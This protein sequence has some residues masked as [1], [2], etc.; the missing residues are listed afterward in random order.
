LIARAWL[1][2]APS[3]ETVMPGASHLLSEEQRAAAAARTRTP[4]PSRADEVQRVASGA[5]AAVGPSAALAVQGAVGNAALGQVL[6]QRAGGSSRRGGGGREKFDELVRQSRGPGSRRSSQDSRRSSEDS[7]QGDLYNEAEMAL[8]V[9]DPRYVQTHDNQSAQAG[10]GADGRPEISFD[11]QHQPLHSYTDRDAW[12]MG[13]A[14][15]EPGHFRMQQTYGQTNQQYGLGDDPDMRWAN[16]PFAGPDGSQEFYASSARQMGHVDEAMAR[17]R[18]AVTA[19]RH[20][21]GDDLTEHLLGRVPYAQ[22]QSHVHFDT[23]LSDMVTYM[24]NL[25]DA[26]FRSEV[27]GTYSYQL[28]RSLSVAAFGRRNEPGA[29]QEIPGVDEQLQQAR[30]R[31]HRRRRHGRHH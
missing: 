20:L 11:P 26:R 29:S 14:V 22:A 7:H 10:F 15:H 9:A 1:I 25:R 18:N 27:R 30:D 31:G 21:L 4:S 5:D 13:S 28:I 19:D 23:V 3:K 16:M 17:V 24:N 2:H 6:V 8:Q 12:V